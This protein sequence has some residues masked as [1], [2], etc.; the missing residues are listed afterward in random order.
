MVWHFKQQATPSV[1]TSA[2]SLRR[3][4]CIRTRRTRSW[5]RLRRRRRTKRRWRSRRTEMRRK[6]MAEAEEEEGDEGQA[7]RLARTRRR[8]RSCASPRNWRPSCERGTTRRASPWE[9]SPGPRSGRPSGIPCATPACGPSRPS[10]CRAFRLS[11]F[12][13]ARWCGQHR[14]SRRHLLAPAARSGTRQRS[15]VPFRGALAFADARTLELPPSGPWPWQ[16]TRLGLDARPSRASSRSSASSWGT[17]RGPWR[18]EGSTCS[19]P[20]PVRTT[21]PPSMGTAG[22]IRRLPRGREG[23]S[24]PRRRGWIRR[25]FHQS[26]RERRRWKRLQ[27]A[28]RRTSRTSSSSL[29]MST[30]WGAPQRG[31][32]TKTTSGP[33]C[34]GPFAFR[35]L[36]LRAKSL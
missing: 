35:R 32:T 25:C 6:T 14:P 5:W 20:W 28:P 8:P 30:E 19:A 23:R 12:S 11:C 9:P 2:G 1:P 24:S 31:T 18:S 36:W 13:T 10:G 17:S 4:S 16:A 7:A 29:C 33:K 22:A 15:P 21:R 26:T 3:S 27:M 34:S